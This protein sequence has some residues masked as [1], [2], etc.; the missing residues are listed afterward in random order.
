MGEHDVSLL[1]VSLK[2]NP[3]VLLLKNLSTTVQDGPS[4][5]GTTSA[6]IGAVRQGEVTTFF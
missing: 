4:H 2:I 3:I 6:H 1:L 5:A